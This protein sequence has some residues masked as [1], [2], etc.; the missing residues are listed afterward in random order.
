MFKITVLTINYNNDKGLIKTIDS[1]VNQTYQEIEFIVIDGDSNDRSVSILKSHNGSIDY[2]SSERDSGIYNAMNK[3]IY[4][5]SGDFLMFLNSGDYFIN[6]TALEELTKGIDKNN[7]AY[8]G[9]ALIFNP[10]NA[11]SFLNPKKN[12]NSS[13]KPSYFFTPNHQAILFPRKFYSNNYYNES[14]SICSDADYIFR[15]SKEHNL[16]HVNHTIVVFEIGGISNTFNNLSKT[17]RHSK[18]AILIHSQHQNNKILAHTYVPLKFLIKYIFDSIT[19]LI[20]K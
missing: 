3:G 4:K 18:E 5:S 11:K 19:K 15:L 6:S 2:W 8:Y 10:L 14:F 12:Q 9:N 20:K 17:I 1:V 7:D 13:Y 16:R